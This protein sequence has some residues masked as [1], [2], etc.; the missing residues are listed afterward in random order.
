MYTRRKELK[1][2]Q[3]NII[4]YYELSNLDYKEFIVVECDHLNLSLSTRYRCSY[5]S[6]FISEFNQRYPFLDRRRV[7]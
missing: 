4:G 2:H 6:K 5:F 1:I 3:L 7:H